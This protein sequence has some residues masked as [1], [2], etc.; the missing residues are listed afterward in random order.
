[1]KEEQINW[2]EQV[3]AEERAKKE[4]ERVRNGYRLWLA[5]DDLTP[6]PPGT[7]EFNSLVYGQIIHKCP[8]MPQNVSVWRNTVPPGEYWVLN[9]EQIFSCPYCNANLSYGEGERFLT[10]WKRGE[11]YYQEQ[12]VRDF[13]HLDEIDGG[14]EP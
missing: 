8:E 13:Y 1:M 12:T 6:C 11:T 4:Q 9:G 10:K 2:F 7:R 3:E 14:E 5:A